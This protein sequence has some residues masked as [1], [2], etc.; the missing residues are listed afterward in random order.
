MQKKYEN[1]INCCILYTRDHTQ[2]LTQDAERDKV[3]FNN[4]L[5]K[6]KRVRNCEKFCF[7]YVY[8]E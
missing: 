7:M 4:I 5:E 3:A 2:T 6:K 8:Q 1:E